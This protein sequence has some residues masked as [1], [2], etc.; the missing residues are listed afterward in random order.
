[1]T[2]QQ[3]SADEVSGPWNFYGTIIYLLWNRTTY[4]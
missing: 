1:M 2:L 4:R 3:I